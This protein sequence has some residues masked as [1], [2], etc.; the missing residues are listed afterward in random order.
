MLYSL[1]SLLLIVGADQAV[2]YWAR[3]SLEPVRS[4]PILNGFLEFRYAENT[5][6]A[7]SL[8]SGQRWFFILIT[9]VFL[10]AVILIFKKQYFKAK[11]SYIALV[12]VVGGAVGNFIDRILHGYVVDMFNFTFIDFAI[13]NV[14]DIFITMGGVLMFVSLLFFEKGKHAAPVEA[15]E[16]ADPALEDMETVS[17]TEEITPEITPEDETPQTPQESEPNDHENH[18]S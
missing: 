11:L 15:A 13:F 16:A 17:E 10:A 3:L 4:M 1:L 12:L 2:K 5:G 7:F 14:A 18:L 8:L 9:V 6:A